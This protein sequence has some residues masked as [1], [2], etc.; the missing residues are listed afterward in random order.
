MNKACFLDRDGVL[1][2]DKHYLSDPKDVVLTLGAGA[3][4][5]RLKKAGYLCIVVTNQ[6]GV[7]RGY[8][9]EDDIAGVHKR[10]DELLGAEGAV[11]D[12][13]YNCPHHPNGSIDE[14]SIACDCRKPEP[15][16]LKKAVKDFHIN[17]EESCIVGDKMSDI[18]AG[19]AI[20]CKPYLVLTGHGAE[21][22]KTAR[23]ENAAI[24]ENLAAAAED[25]IN[26]QD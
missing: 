14:F 11:L 2:E 24:F 26:N 23:S 18:L 15:G 7:A 10:L 20:G 5:K 3:A 17:P 1:I 4:V 25:I 19:K 8:F 21:H 6:S 16:M 12:G 22:E 9:T 13:Y